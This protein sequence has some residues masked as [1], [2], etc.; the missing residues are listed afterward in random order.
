MTRTQR[1]TNPHAIIKDRSESKSGLDK[2]VKKQGA[3]PHA[4]G[5]LKDETEHEFGALDDEHLEPDVGEEEGVPKDDPFGK[6]GV[7]TEKQRRDSVVQDV[8]EKA[9]AEAIEIRNGLKKNGD[10]LDLDAIAR[11]SYAVSGSP[12]RTRN[13]AVP[14]TITSDAQTAVNSE[15]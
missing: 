5:S 6:N 4:W 14:V 2:S 13:D 1:S 11:S 15:F 3:G 7:K 9:K 8:D 10:K 12:P